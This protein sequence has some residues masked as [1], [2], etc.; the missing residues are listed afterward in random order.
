MDDTSVPIASTPHN[1]QHSTLRNISATTGEDIQMR[2]FFLR[3]VAIWILATVVLTFI[4][5]CLTRNPYCFSGLGLLAPPF[6]ILY[7]I[8]RF[9]FPKNDRDYE[10]KLEKIKAKYTA[11]QYYKKR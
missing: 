4:L 6:Y 10:V 8:V 5:F 11:K 9:L 7:R 2:W 1:D 3:L